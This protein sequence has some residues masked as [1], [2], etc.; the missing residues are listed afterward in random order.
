M[1]KIAK[2]IRLTSKENIEQASKYFVKDGEGLEEKERNPCC[3]SFEGGGG[4]VSILISD[5][6][7]R[8]ATTYSVCLCAFE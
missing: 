8:Q 4:Y 6:E 5:Q 2:Q 3:I 1:I 7:K